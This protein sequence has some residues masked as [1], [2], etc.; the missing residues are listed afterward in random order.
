MHLRDSPNDPVPAK[1]TEG[2]VAE[3]FDHQ[4]TPVILQTHDD[5]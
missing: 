3:Y 5:T 1:Y 2:G 4:L